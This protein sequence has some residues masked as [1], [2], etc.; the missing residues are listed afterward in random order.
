VRAH[1]PRVR[2][3]ADRAQAQGI[4]AAVRAGHEHRVDGAD[5]AAEVVG[6]GGQEPGAERCAVVARP[7]KPADPPGLDR[8]QDVEVRGEGQH[9]KG[10]PRVLVENLDPVIRRRQV[11]AGGFLQHGGKRHPPIFPRSRSSRRCGA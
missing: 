4:A 11:P 8:R 2:L 10:A 7:E 3:V 6:E 5:A 1:H 9:P